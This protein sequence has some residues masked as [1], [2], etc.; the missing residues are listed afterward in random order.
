MKLLKFLSVLALAACA[1]AAGY[2]AGSR[3]PA[4][5]PVPAT[6]N[7]NAETARLKTKIA[8]L[9]QLLGDAQKLVDKAIRQNSRPVAITDTSAA[10]EISQDGAWDLLGELKKRLS[11]EE[12][13]QVTNA[14][15]EASMLRAAKAQDRLA[16]LE[17]I[18]VSSMTEKERDTHARFIEKFRRREAAM[19]KMKGG[20]PTKESLEELVMSE[21]DLAG[22]AKEERAALLALAAREL[23]LTGGEAASLADAM[24]TVFDCTSSGGIE[25]P[26]ELDGLNFDGPVS[27]DVQTQVIGL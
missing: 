13:A 22:I 17:G 2:L 18:D 8:R 11:D 16:F 14:F 4:P 12:L 20:L 21:V 15:A 7:D 24:G 9:E 19:A 10:A 23:G 26:P 27:F 25:A 3:P 5:Q 1:G 6:E